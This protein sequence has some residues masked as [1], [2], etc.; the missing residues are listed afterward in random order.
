MEY[1]WAQSNQLAQ[2]GPWHRIVWTHE[3]R[4]WHDQEQ[5]SEKFKCYL[6]LLILRIQTYTSPVGV[7]LFNRNRVKY[8]AD[9]KS[10]QNAT[11]LDPSVIQ[12]RWF[13]FL[14]NDVYNPLHHFSLQLQIF[15]K[16]L[17][18]FS[19]QHQSLSCFTNH[20]PSSI[21]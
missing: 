3:S 2:K 16:T 4:S 13:W 5:D 11:I 8:N 12:A 10:W 14:L 7:D 1:S 21:L 17:I 19:C 20:Y 15:L 18:I 9:H 6:C